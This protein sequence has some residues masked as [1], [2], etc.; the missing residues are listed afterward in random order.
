VD[1]LLGEAPPTQVRVGANAPSTLSLATPSVN[2]LLARLCTAEQRRGS[3]RAFVGTV[4][5]SA[6][7]EPLGGAE[8]GFRVRQW[9]RPSG[10]VFSAT[11][12]DVW[13]R[14][15]EDARYEVCLATDDPYVLG[16]TR[17][18]RVAGTYRPLPEGTLVVHDF[19]VGPAGQP[20]A[21]GLP[22]VTEP[23]TPRR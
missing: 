23:R 6:S 5:D 4:R 1:A 9:R 16:T 21:R 3:V 22:Q 13:V 12:E 18:D 19:L 20:D 14:T 8:V 2:A 7:G 10:A 17:I 11:T 15:G